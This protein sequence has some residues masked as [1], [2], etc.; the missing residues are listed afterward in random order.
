MH[1][2]KPLALRHDEARELVEL[3][4]ERGVRLSCA[5]ATLLG[6]AQQ[7]RWK[8]VRDGAS[9]GCGSSTR[10]PT[11]AASSAGTRT[12]RTL[13]AVGPLVD[14]GVY[15]LAILTAM[16]GPVRRVQAY[17]HD[18]RARPCAR[19][20]PPFRLAAPDFV[21]ALLELDGRRRRAPDGDVLGPPIQ[22]ARAR[23]A[24]RRRLALPG[25]VG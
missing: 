15:P 9:D 16:F 12:R 1:T 23:V 22:A 20:R 24:R 18:R 21:V 3:A 8:L 13:Y 4:S 2:E 14:V 7:T 25:G 17:A 5:P 11:G 6:E 19:R 10:R